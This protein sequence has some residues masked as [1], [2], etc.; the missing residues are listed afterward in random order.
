M[1]YGPNTTI[2]HPELSILLNCEIGDGCTI[3][4]QVW[5]GNNV[6]IGNDCMVQ[7]FSFIPE[8]VTIEDGVFIGPHVCFTNDKRPPSYGDHWGRILVKKGASIG[9]N[10]TILP[11][12]I[13]GEGAVI[14]AGSVV[15]KDVPAGETWV[16]N[17]ARPIKQ[18]EPKVIAPFDADYYGGV[19]SGAGNTPG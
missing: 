16:G 7:A 5:I 8:G 12:V 13:I 1:K 19:T 18:H 2:W 4:G 11:G 17:P 3:H 6:K 14:G 15:T 10:A 9:A